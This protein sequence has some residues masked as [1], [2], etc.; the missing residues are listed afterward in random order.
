MS[1]EQYRKLMQDRIEYWVRLAREH[2]A[3]PIGYLRRGD[4]KG[5][6]YHRGC[7]DMAIS[8]ARDCQD[9]L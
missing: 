7:R 3:Q 1:E 2:S 9:L 8:A 6:H 5:Y 4:A